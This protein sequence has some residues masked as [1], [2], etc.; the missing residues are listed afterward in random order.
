MNDEYLAARRAILQ[1]RNQ[2]V[3]KCQGV[4]Q[5]RYYN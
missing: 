1:Y 2:R 3:L 4:P 5:K